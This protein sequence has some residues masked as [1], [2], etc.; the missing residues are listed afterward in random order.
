MD[1]RH[2]LTAAMLAAVLGGLI[3][4]TYAQERH[5]ARGARDQVMRGMQDRD[6]RDGRMMSRG[7]MSGGTM[8]GCCIGMMQSMNG[9]AGRPNSQ[10]RAHPSGS[11]TSE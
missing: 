8:G 5:R 9:G 2:P 10:W 4:P 3:L 6:H 11:A 7:E 1:I